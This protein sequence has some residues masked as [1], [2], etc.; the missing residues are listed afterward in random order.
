MIEYTSHITITP[1]N[2]M[3]SSKLLT[4]QP[5]EKPHFLRTKA[6]QTCV[7][8]LMIVILAG[9]MFFFEMAG[10]QFFFEIFVYFMA[11]LISGMFLIIGIA[12][13]IT[14]RQQK[15]LPTFDIRYT[16]R[17]DGV[18]IELDNIM[19]HYHWAAYDH[20]L[21][22]HEYWLMVHKHW[23]MQFHLLE[24]VH[25]S[26]ELQKYLQSKLRVVWAEEVTKG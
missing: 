24:V 23:K 18:I 15:Q 14:K 22:G 13:L 10:L 16:F 21:C 26:D 1:K 2:M 17:E 6:G 9:V 7:T 11:G 4:T 5:P 19:S 12:I 20:L 8:V 3:E 25:L